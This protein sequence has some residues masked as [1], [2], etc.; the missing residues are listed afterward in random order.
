MLATE[1]ADV[2]PWTLAQGDLNTYIEKIA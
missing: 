2:E 1:Q